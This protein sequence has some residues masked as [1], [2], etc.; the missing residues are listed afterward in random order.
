ML[1]VLA[2]LVF[3]TPDFL[4]KNLYPN[5]IFPVLRNIY[6]Y[7][8]GFLPFPSIY[9][10]LPFWIFVI[11]TY[12]KKE[13]KGKGGFSVLSKVIHIL[14]FIYVTFYWFWGLNYKNDNLAVRLDLEPIEIS[15]EDV[16]D[17]ASLVMKKVNALRSELGSPI[18]AL[19]TLYDFNE[20]EDSLRYHLEAVL[21][22]LN[23][24]NSGRVRARALQ[25][26]GFLL[27]FSTSGIY[28]PFVFEGHIDGG[29]YHVQHPFTAAHEMAH[30]YGITN[31][32]ECNFL[33]ILVCAGSQDKYIQYSGLL[34][35]WRYMANDVL[36]RDRSLGTQLLDQRS[37]GVICDVEE[38]FKTF[39]K[40]PDIL[41]RWRDF[42]YDAYLKNN[43]IREGL[44]SYS[45]V[46]NY[47]FS[48]KRSNYTRL[49]YNSIYN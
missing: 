30:G 7:S 1:L 20:V 29:L 25:P 11:V 28:I 10:L 31:E 14:L 15:K 3:F 6:D 23:L 45:S 38:I 40:Y 27:R 4:S 13:R 18:Y 2:A 33:A 26:D 46:S 47:M 22:E 49:I 16:F 32:G 37:E 35:Y 48:W 24:P 36:R 34:A 17:E 12:V 43:G 21:S 9:L 19:P 39:E 41:P 5:Y 44:K 8:L 42:I